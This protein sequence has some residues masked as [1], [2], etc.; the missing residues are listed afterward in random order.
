MPHRDGVRELLR[1]YLAQHPEDGARIAPVLALVAAESRC[2][3]RDAL[4]GHLTA[5]AWIF[6]HDLRRSLLTHHRKLGRWLQLGGHADGEVHLHEVALR[7]AREESGL[8]HFEIVRTRGALSPLDVDVHWIPPRPARPGAREEPG[9]WHH[10]V[11]F[12]LIAG[13]EREVVASEESVELRWF[14]DEDVQ[15]AT[16]EESVLR[17]LRRARARMHEAPSDLRDE[18]A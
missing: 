7:E 15:Q 10:D 3:E 13:G 9:H 17:L 6:S 2:F 14:T 18:G 16:S 12:L 1:R 11:R 5:S 4:P 8:E